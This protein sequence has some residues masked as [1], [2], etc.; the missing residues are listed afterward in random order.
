MST[1]F[2]ANFGTNTGYAWNT[3]ERVFRGVGERLLE[4][5][6]RVIV[7]YRDLEGGP[8]RTLEG[9]ALEV[10]SFDY[11]GIDSLGDA[12][13]FARLLRRYDVR[14]LYLTD[15]PTWSPY[16]PL[17]RLAGVRRIIVHDRTSGSR[18]TG[19]ASRTLKRLIHATPGLAAD[20]FI[21][22]SRFVARRLI[23][24]SGTPSSRTVVI[25]NG[26]DTARF[27][28]G[29]ASYLRRTLD[30]PGDRH[31]VFFSGRM[32]A[33]KGVATLIEAATILSGDGAPSPVF[34]FCGEGPD[35]PSFKSLAEEGGADCRFL[36]RRED[37]ERLL[38][39]ATVAVVPSLWE[40]AFGLTVVEAMAAG[41]PV[42]ATAVGGIPELLRDGEDGVLV[43]AGDPRRMADRIGWLLREDDIRERI[44][45]AARHEARS[46]FDIGRTIDEIYGVIRSDRGGPGREP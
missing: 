8:P 21:G 2:V 6:E 17:F 12:I 10:V 28:G 16:Y 3:I 36:G 44:G 39:G 25:Y 11:L 5:G 23:R 1:L 9:A 37:V 13:A 20:I 26:I 7:C 35:L 31:V 24:V 4:D 42:I 46:R 43:P 32:Q 33:Y 19:A 14:T 40:E 38:P 29:D 15:R 30:I 22:V 34:V 27:A 45:N 41:V 18:E